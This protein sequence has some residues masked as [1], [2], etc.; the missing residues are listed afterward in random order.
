MERSLVR[1]TFLHLYDFCISQ[2]HH[3]KTKAA[4]TK[5]KRKSGCAWP[6]EAHLPLVCPFIPSVPAGRWHPASRLRPPRDKGDTGSA[7][8]HAALSPKFQ[9]AVAAFSNPQKI[10]SEIFPCEM[11]SDFVFLYENPV[12]PSHIHTHKRARTHAR[13]RLFILKLQRQAHPSPNFSEINI[14]THRFSKLPHAVGWS[15]V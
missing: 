1:I 4:L 11:T 13:A 15:E 8:S 5:G 14:L 10:L 6:R 12:K 3:F 7:Q 9:L 2:T